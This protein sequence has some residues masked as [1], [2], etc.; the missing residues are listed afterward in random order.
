[1]LLLLFLLG[2]FKNYLVMKG[3]IKKGEKEKKKAIE[4]GEVKL[5]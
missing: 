5:I 1:M 3:V 2:G 4:K